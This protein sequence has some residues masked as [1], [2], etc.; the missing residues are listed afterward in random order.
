MKV[1]VVYLL[2]GGI[3]VCTFDPT[4]LISCIA[5]FK[6]VQDMQESNLQLLGQR[7]DG[8]CT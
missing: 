5:M 2:I 8:P 6:I 4:R 1:K 3:K 7:F